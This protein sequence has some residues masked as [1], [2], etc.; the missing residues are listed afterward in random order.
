MAYMS[1]RVG[2]EGIGLYQLIM[3]IYMLAATFASSGI[4]IAVSRLTAEA[5]AKSGGRSTSNRASGAPC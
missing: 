5:V 3:S 1:G 4:G 2:E